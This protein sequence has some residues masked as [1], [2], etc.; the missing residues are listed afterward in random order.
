MDAFF[1]TS[2][3]L[4]TASLIRS[5]SAIEFICARILRIFPALW[6][7]S[8]ITIFLFGSILTN[9]PLFNYLFNA[10]LWE[11]AAKS[12]TLLTGLPRDL[13]GVF[14][15]NPFGNRVNGSLWTL[16]FEIQMYS[17]LLATWI[18]SSIA[19]SNRHSLFKIFII[20]FC[21]LSGIY[22]IFSYF[23]RGLNIRFELHE[24]YRFQSLFFMFF[25]GATFYVLRHRIILSRL[26][27]WFF[28]IIFLISLRNK[29][30]FLVTY[31]FTLSYLFFYIAF[32]PNYKIRI[33][34][35][36]GDYSYGIY[37]YA[38]PVQQGTIYLT[39]NISPF[40]LDVI[41]A[42]ITLIF[43]AISWHFVEK[44]ALNA[45]KSLSHKILV[46]FNYRCMTK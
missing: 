24:N 10:S 4:V 32:I 21:T 35:R 31:I 18:L 17:I 14:A 34:N 5:Q 26:F 39:N 25:T 44:T 33:F 27:F 30:L 12:V 11:Y 41:S 9:L 23:Q 3:F 28:C 1:L 13:P 40:L 20:S 7:M 42:P 36:F 45:K 22:I 8:L 6:I 29:H 38:F 2:G 15:N 37:I 16:P 43:A 46:Y 19:G